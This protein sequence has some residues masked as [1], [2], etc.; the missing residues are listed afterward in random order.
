VV[1]VKNKQQAKPKRSV[2]KRWI[3]IGGV[4]L[5]GLLAITLIIVLNPPEQVSSSLP[6]VLTPHMTYEVIHIYPHDPDA[7]TQG[8]I[9][10]DGYL[11]ESTGLYGESSLRK[12]DLET[13]AVLAQTDL[14]PQFF[15]EGM[16]D[17]EENLVQLTWREGTGF[18]YDRSELRLTDEFRYAT[19][20]W[21]LTQD[22][23]R[24]ILSDGTDQL[25]FLDPVSFEV[26]GAVA[27]TWQGAG[28]QRLNEL[29]WVR[30]EI[31]A[32]IWQTD[33]L[34][35]I[36][37]A[38]GAVTGWIDLSGLLPASEHTVRTDVLN[39]IA[40]DPDTDRLFVTGKRWPYL[41][42]I[43]LVPVDTED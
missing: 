29:E 33:D 37:P 32:N 15:A 6:Q 23:T 17:W 7:F 26:M 10:V 16:T 38:S 1:R 8:L 40:Y 35:R 3:V 34:I 2:V 14:P 9:Y 21:G 43:R 24:L 22:G 4:L 31:F 20:G 11:Y 39:G 18:V 42:E 27:V 5:V 19:E 12:V 36:D 30:G 41:Y 13:G 28:V 25:Y